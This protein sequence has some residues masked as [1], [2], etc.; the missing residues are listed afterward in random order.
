MARYKKKK[1]NR[2]L[3]PPK[4]RVKPAVKVPKNDDIIMEKA[5]SKNKKAKPEQPK[6]MHVV[7]G[8]KGERTRRLKAVG[9]LALGLALVILLLE[10]VFPAGVFQTLSNA[11]ATIGAGS[12]PI[13]VS[14]SE[15]LSVVPF[16]NYFYHLTDTH[17]SA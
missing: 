7:K 3:N 16:G 1:H 4:K 5:P 13:A 9:V 11:V 10:V 17:I 14:G 12:F 8:K 2:I 6:T 15:T